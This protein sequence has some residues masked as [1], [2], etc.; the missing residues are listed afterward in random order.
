MFNTTTFLA[1]LVAVAVTGPSGV[2]AQIGKNNIPPN[3]TTGNCVSGRMPFDQ[4]RIFEMHG[5]E[6]KRY[7]VD[8]S[9]YDFTHSYGS[10]TYNGNTASLNVVKSN[11]PSKLADGVLLST[12]RYMR[13]GKVTARLN[14]AVSPGIVTTFVTWSDKQAPIPNSLE[15]V[16]D[17]IDWEILGRDVSRP[18]TNVFT[19][20]TSNLERGLHGGPVNG[21]I[22]PGVH[23]YS[24][25]WRNDRIV[26]SVDGRV[27]KT[28]NKAESRGLPGSLPPGQF[29][30]PESA[31]RIQV[32]IWDGTTQ[33][34]WAGGPIQFNPSNTVS[35]VYEWLEVQCYNDDMQPVSTWSTD[36]TG[37]AKPEAPPPP[38]PS[39]PGSPT[40]PGAPGSRSSLPPKS[41]SAIVP[42]SMNVLLTSIVA[43]IAGIAAISFM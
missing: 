4:K 26:W 10:V 34:N 23:E 15:Y 41:S 2:M 8:R 16:Q 30:F 9:Q 3:F 1:L 22:T 39:T 32:S 11:D 36:G 18:E 27:V 20:K 31:S 5:D 14:P 7:T 21:V 12:T 17:E 6:S 33:A 42:T 29:W 25:E 38:S 40:G 19:Y 37:A 28:L 43:S 35:S 24:I 13:F